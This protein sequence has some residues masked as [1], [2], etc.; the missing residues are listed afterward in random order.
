MLKIIVCLFLSL[1][2]NVS[3]FG[4]KINSASLKPLKYIN[5]K[6]TD[7]AYLEQ[8]RG[9]PV[10]LVHG[11]LG[12]YR[13]W[14]A[15]IT[16][17]SKSYKV[18]AYSRR[19]HFPNNWV[20]DASDYSL[21]LHAKDLAA[22]IKELKLK[23]PVHLIGHSYGGAVAAIVAS[24]HPE[25]IKSLVLI[26]PRLL[27]LL[28]KTS[29][30]DSYNAERKKTTQKIFELLKDGD[31]KQA[32]KTFLSF[33]RGSDG[34]EKISADVFEIMEDNVRTLKPMLSAVEPSNIFTCEAA[35]KIKAPTLLVRGEISPKIYIPVLAQL[36]KCLRKSEQITISG[37]S[38]GVMQ[39]NPQAFNKTVLKFLKQY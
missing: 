25:M 15:Q 9:T 38:H 19:Y 5:L 39:E 21:M 6:D 30:T 4:Q 29:E 35:Q 16:A 23:K 36:E 32:V 8:G 31:D 22:F 11:G 28:P 12:D 3:F 14:N 17:F 13:S 34:I 33:T 20:G 10:I 2:L 27:Q 1:L 26:E 24:Q 7:L 37:S 18:V